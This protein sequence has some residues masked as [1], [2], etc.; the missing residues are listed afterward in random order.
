[1]P[2]EEGFDKYKVTIAAV[3]GCILAA[4]VIC[5]ILSQGTGAQKE[6]EFSDR[7]VPHCPYCGQMV[8]PYADF[9]QECNR[10]FRLV[11]KTVKCYNCGGTGLCPA[12]QG[13]SETTYYPEGGRQP[14]IID[15]CWQCA[16]P[17][18]EGN[19]V[20]GKERMI[21]KSRGPHVCPV[22]RGEGWIR[23]GGAS[24]EYYDRRQ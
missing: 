24:V 3:A 17:E 7:G 5:I 9:C 13:V 23:Y 20:R 1:M 18:D 16:G 11:N 14:P 6:V 19:D 4:V 12:C 22:C 8:A 10:S 21:K 15:R 2:K